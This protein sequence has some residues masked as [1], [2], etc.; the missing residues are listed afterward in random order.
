MVVEILILILDLNGFRRSGTQLHKYY[1]NGAS[2]E[3]FTE[4]C[5]G[6]TIFL[7]VTG[8]RGKPYAELDMGRFSPSLASHNFGALLV[9]DSCSPL[10]P[11]QPV[12]LC[13]ALNR[14]MHDAIVWS[15]AQ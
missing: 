8:F 1:P 10:H 15:T 5:G 7:V 13:P 6:F 11:Q 3:N 9:L 14:E 12:Q 4:Y 2:T